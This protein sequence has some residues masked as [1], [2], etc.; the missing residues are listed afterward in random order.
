VTTSASRSTPQSA[1]YRWYILTVATLTFT[2]VMA[3]PAMSLPVL[4]DEISKEMNLSLVQIGWIWGIGSLMGIAVGLVGGAISDRFGAR[5]MLAVSCL[6]VGI[7]GAAR[8]FAWNFNSL[9]V[10]MFLLGFAQSAIPMNVHKTCGVWF[11]QQLGMANGIVSVG[12]AFGFMLGSLLAATVISPLLGGW[13]NVFFVYGVIA[14]FFSLLWWTT[15]EKEQGNTTQSSGHASIGA[16]LRYVTSIPNVW[17]LALATMGVGSC[18]GATLGYLPLYLRSQG[19]STTSADSAL[20]SFHA[21]SMICAIPIALLSDRLGVRRGILMAGAAMVTT[22]VIMLAVT[23]GSLVWVAVIIAGMM[24]DGFMAITMTS[25]IEV[26]GVGARYAGSATGFLMA[27]GGLGNVIAPPLGNSLAAFSPNAPFF[28]WAGM[29]ATGFCM[30]LF[31][32]KDTG[33]TR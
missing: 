1:N 23:H 29:A 6:I 21:V 30:Y 33:T 26:K 25:M 22:G 13:R 5:R 14:L 28:L 8:G 15:Q 3:I 10:A 12:M 16:A 20:A 4:F 9:A 11:P 24:R 7:F 27:W 18:V 17:F 19:W 32:K 31:L 2:F